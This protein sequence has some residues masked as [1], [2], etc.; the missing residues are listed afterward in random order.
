MEFQE[1]NAQQKNG[2]LQKLFDYFA[3][4]HYVLV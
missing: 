2:K 4:H 1:R 3:R